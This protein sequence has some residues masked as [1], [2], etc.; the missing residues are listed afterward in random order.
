M[1]MRGVYALAEIGARNSFEFA[2]DQAKFFSGFGTLAANGGQALVWQRLALPD[3]AMQFAGAA[4]YM[5]TLGAGTFSPRLEQ[6]RRNLAVAG[7]GELFITAQV[8]EAGQLSLLHGVGIGLRTMDPA[9]PSV[10]SRA[11]AQ[12]NV[13]SLYGRHLDGV[14]VSVGGQ[15]AAIVQAWPNQV[16]IKL[17]EPPAQALNVELDG[18]AGRVPAVKV[19]I[20]SALPEFAE[21]PA[22]P[23]GLIAPER[24]AAPGEAIEL[25]ITGGALPAGA[26]VLFDGIAGDV[27]SSAL[28]GGLQRV[29]ITLPKSLVPAGPVNVAV[30]AP[31]YYVDL[32]DITVNRP[33]VTSGAPAPVASH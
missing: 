23:G 15:P 4:A 2:P 29:K 7:D 30:A 5:V 9:P 14:Q 10:A 24:A 25:G 11:T 3:S 17:A 20:G 27:V 31:G 6:R 33:R 26:A 1:S 16:N 19:A 13:V 18:P 21:A 22:A 8:A 12:G 28:V 32:G